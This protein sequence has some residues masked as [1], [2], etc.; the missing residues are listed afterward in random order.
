[1]S[2]RPLQLAML[3]LG[4]GTCALIYQTTWLRELRLV[5]GASTP[6]SAAVLAIFMG[7]LGAGGLLLSQRA[8]KHEQPL[9]LY[10]TLELLIALSTALTPGLL[11]LV[12]QIY[13]G[14]GG[15]QALGPLFGTVSRLL[16]S[17]IVLSVPTLL[18][19]GTLPAAARA[20]E[21]ERDERRRNVAVLYGLNTVGAVCGSLLSTFYLIE[22]FG[23]R[24]SLWL[25]CLLN[26]G[27]ALAAFRMARE[28]T[29]TPIEEDAPAPAPAATVAADAAA[30]PPAPP[31][32]VVVAA[33]VVGLTFLLMELVW[34]RMLG[35]LLGGSS[36]TFGLILAV[37]LLGIGIGGLLY[38][39]FGQDRQPT[40]NGF[41]LT[42][43]LEAIGL[44]LPYA[45]GDRVAM[46]TVSLRS[47]KLLGFGGEVLGWAQVT[48]LVVLPAAI[49]SGY[50]FPLLIGLLGRGRTQVSRHVALAY[51]WNTGGAIV[52]SLLGGFGLMPLLLATGTWRLAV[53]LL[54]GLGV[55]AMAL[56][57]R[58]EQRKDQPLD[59]PLLPGLG[60]LLVVA[61][62]NQPGPT[63]VWRHV[64]IGVGREEMPSDIGEN[65]LQNWSNG[66]RRNILWERDGVESSVAL[67]SNNGLAFVVN[68]KSDGSA[69]GDAPTFLMG[70]LIG[71]IAH[72][73]GRGQPKSALVVGLGTGITAGWLAAIPSIERVDVAEIEPAIQDVA[74]ACAAA[75]HDVMNNPKLRLLVADG[76]EI[77]LTTKQRYDLIMSQPS[78]PY[79][80]GIA[81]LYTQEYYRS[82]RRKLTESGLFLQW[83]QAYDVDDQTVRTIYATLSSI[84]PHVETWF[85][86]QGDL[87]LVAGERPLNYD[88][89][90]LRSRI[91]EEPYKTALGRIMRINTVEGLLA[92]YLA[93]AKLTQAIKLGEKDRINTDD[94][95][96]V[97]FTFARSL[98]GLHLFALPNLMEAA[99]A[100]GDD[101][102]PVQNGTLDPDRFDERRIAMFTLTGAAPPSLS[103]QS[104]VLRHRAFVHRAYTAGNLELAANAWNAL[105][106]KL[107]PGATMSID[108]LE[109]TLLAEVY[110]QTKDERAPAAIERLR[111]TQPTEAD[112]LLGRWLM[113]KDQPVEA[114]AAFESAF[115]RFREDPWP[116]TPLMNRTLKA[117]TEVGSS[118]LDLGKRLYEAL[119]P[120]F[121]VSILREERLIALLSIATAEPFETHCLDALSLVGP[122]ILWQQS[123]LVWRANC[124]RVTGKLAEAEAA[125]GDLVRFQRHQPLPF[126]SL[127]PD[128][129]GPQ[130]AAP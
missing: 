116:M 90:A 91:Q 38:S 71:A 43:L 68:G 30:A 64:G 32:F 103:Y 9:R 123:F 82:A 80:A 12:R 113:Q 44:A 41:A 16:L 117:A 22:R 114:T 99:H 21:T 29:A 121:A 26:A 5:F 98:D 35:P 46:L 126:L 33:A 2:S 19:G 102:P 60:V 129:V 7:G 119:R 95:T 76:R 51:A 50:Q 31:A 115:K 127:S 15:E 124:Y 87:L 13:I 20:A 110:T 111:L 53:W 88:V 69:R 8:E 92:H 52:G 83:L 25:A 79:R 128:P 125:R 40:L 39:L 28:W 81:S 1:M 122:H 48:A 58:A 84:F 4:S 89:A 57:L 77:L 101:R 27:V 3:L 10:A 73:D 54:I 62:I 59:L 65:S 24:S 37:A 61:L 104:P 70:G 109:E 78:N 63:A 49:V 100:L 23:N 105:E 14:V 86:Q 94:R 47:L 130:P 85:T 36:F 97:E 107:P 45:L 56:A 55:A 120:P 67:D 106:Q 11:W 18:M 6:A 66:R 93:G 118:R 74:R 96:E 17:A 34:Y 108:P 42:C 75:N 112:A 72:N